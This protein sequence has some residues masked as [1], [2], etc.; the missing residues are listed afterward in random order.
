MKKTKRYIDIQPKGKTEK[1]SKILMDQDNQKKI[2]L[3]NG[4][5]TRV[6]FRQ[7]YAVRM[8][9]RLYCL[10]YP[11]TPVRNLEE[12]VGLIF[13]VADESFTL[14]KDPRT[15][16]EIFDSYYQCLRGSA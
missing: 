1:A 14:V 11:I 6:V 13:E 10:M 9:E 15:T 16:K 12:Q 2:I 4:K 7:V 3:K 8:D 5:G